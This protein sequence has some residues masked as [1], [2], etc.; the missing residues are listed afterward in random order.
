MFDGYGGN[1]GSKFYADYPG[2][3][4]DEIILRPAVSLGLFFKEF[5]GDWWAPRWLYQWRAMMIRYSRTQCCALLVSISQM[6]HSLIFK[7]IG[8]VLPLFAGFAWI[9]LLWQRHRPS[10]TIVD[11]C[12]IMV[13]FGEK[14]PSMDR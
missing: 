11:V 5:G 10:T 13:Y 8:C 12:S 7:M 14:R 9:R 4:L 1:C 3:A 6:A 2:L